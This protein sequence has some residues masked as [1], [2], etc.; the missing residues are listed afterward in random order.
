MELNWINLRK[1]FDENSYFRKLSGAEIYPII[2]KKQDIIKRG[3]ID[4]SELFKT[5][6]RIYK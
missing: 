4:Y 3:H 6:K 5:I 2:D 1:Y